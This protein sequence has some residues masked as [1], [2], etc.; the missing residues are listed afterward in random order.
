VKSPIE[1]IESFREY[2][3]PPEMLHEHM[4]RFAK[5]C[6][7]LPLGVNEMY[8]VVDELTACV[9]RAICEH[10]AADRIT[11]VEYPHDSLRIYIWCGEKLAEWLCKATAETAPEV[12]AESVDPTKPKAVWLGGGRV[13]VGDETL[14]LEFQEASVLEALVELGA[15]TRPD[16]ERRSGVEDAVGVL[17]K[18]TKKFPVLA[19]HIHL[20]GGRGKG[21]YRTTIRPAS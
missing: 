1:T 12:E 19:L 20:P 10:A 5:E 3:V 8:W 17:K 9:C 15:A 13:R 4:V 11:L 14:A 2:P 7:I 21:G 18:L 6:S 16:L